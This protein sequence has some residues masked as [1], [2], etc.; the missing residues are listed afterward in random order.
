MRTRLNEQGS[1]PAL[2]R[3]IERFAATKKARTEK[4]LADDPLMY[5]VNARLIDIQPLNLSNLDQLAQQI[6]QRAEAA[7]TVAA[8]T[9][10]V[11]TSPLLASEAVRAHDMLKLLPLGQK[12]A[13]VRQLATSMDPTMI[14]ALGRQIDGKDNALGSA[15]FAAA[16]MPPVVSELILQGADATAAGR[17]K[18]DAVSSSA[19]VQIARELDKVAW[20][21]T[22]ARD[23]A[24]AAAQRV[25]AGLRDRN[26]SAKRH[27]RRSST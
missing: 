9:G 18:E 20:P 27:P 14:A 10:G 6:G 11:P 24:V 19:A 16:S 17:V 5:G 8:R 15:I 21:T 13:V 7:H 23:S 3:R 2:E 12:T 26:G 22:S 4:Q 1:N 25:Y